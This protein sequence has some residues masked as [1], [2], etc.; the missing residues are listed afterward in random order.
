[1]GNYVFTLTLMFTQGL[2]LGQVSILLL[3]YFTLKYLF[4]DSKSA[5]LLDESSEDA[6]FFRPTFFAEKLLELLSFKQR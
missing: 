2:I 6:P 3:V 5:Q 1:M 4:F